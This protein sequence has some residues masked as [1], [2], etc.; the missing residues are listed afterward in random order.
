MAMKEI[1]F[2]FEGA[3]FTLAYSRKTTQIMAQQGFKTN[4]L[5][6]APALGVP[7]LFKGAF[8]VHHRG[9]KSDLVDKIYEALENKDE[10]LS[11]L[12]EM[13]SDPIN[14]LFEDSDDATKKVGWKQNF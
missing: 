10:L 6:D 13:Y 14:A 7:M 11:A 9:I 12:I 4:M 5:T 8:L 1:T 2:E 3:T